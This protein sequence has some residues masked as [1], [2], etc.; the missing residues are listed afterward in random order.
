LAVKLKRFLNPKAL[1]FINRIAGLVI[2]VFGLWLIY[3]Y[4]L[5]IH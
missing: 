1:M 4:A 2:M 3:K 5:K